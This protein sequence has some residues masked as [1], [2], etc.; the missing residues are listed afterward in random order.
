MTHD[1]ASQ[2][3]ADL[4]EWFCGFGFDR[5]EAEQK[6]LTWMR[7]PLGLRVYP[8]GERIDV[9]VCV[10]CDDDHPLL[11]LDNEVADCSK[12][13]RRVQHRPNCPAGP[14]TCLHCAAVMLPQK[15]P[16]I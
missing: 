5:A 10:P 15:A 14:K 16:E 9:I 2:L 7:P 4:V 8:P 3:L 11:L 12:C 1:R 6:A 13:G